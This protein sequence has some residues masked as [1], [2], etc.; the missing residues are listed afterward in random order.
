MGYVH[1]SDTEIGEI[2]RL[3][4]FDLIMQTDPMV[5]SNDIGILAID[6]QAME[7]YGQWPWS[8]EIIA[9]LVWNLR[10]AGAYEIIIPIIMTEEDRLG[11]DMALA[12]ALAGA[13]GVI[14]A[15]VGST[16]LPESKNPV[17]RGIAKI[18][19][20]LLWLY[21]WKGMLG[22]IPL[23]GLNAAGVGVL[24]TVQ[25]IDGVVR[26]LQLFMAI[27]DDVYP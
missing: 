15:Q 21:T 25:E 5:H 16:Q 24:N 12:E 27:G 8:R 3:K 6:E 23:L 19:D 26:R 7:T 13:Q 17:P 11:G 4:Q 20:P 9:N 22:P 2:A 18:G 10:E 14:I 1:Y